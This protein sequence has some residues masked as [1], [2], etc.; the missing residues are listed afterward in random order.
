[1]NETIEG[2]SVMFKKILLNSSFIFCACVVF[3]GVWRIVVIATFFWQG[4]PLVFVEELVY[5]FGKVV[6]EDRLEHEFLFRNNSNGLVRVTS[7]VPACGSCVEVMSFPSI[8]IKPQGYGT[9]RLRLVTSGQKG[10]IAKD[11][12]LKSDHPRMRYLILTLKATLPL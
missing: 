11:V 8:P 1:V 10:E 4:Q 12:I 6:L 3:C 7:V 2:E 5:D 9:V